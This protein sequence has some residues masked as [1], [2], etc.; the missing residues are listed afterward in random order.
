MKI[1]AAMSKAEL[2]TALGGLSLIETF[3][4]M[5]KLRLIVKQHHKMGQ[6]PSAEK[7]AA[8]IRNCRRHRKEMRGEDC[9]IGRLTT[10]FECAGIRWETPAQE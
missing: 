9:S 4:L 6:L 10:A 1:T 5:D 7:V 8:E 2:R 3:Y